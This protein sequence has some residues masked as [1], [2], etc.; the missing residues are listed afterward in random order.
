ME[1]YHLRSLCLSDCPT[2]YIY[3]SIH[4]SIH[5][6]VHPSICPSFRQSTSFDI[7]CSFWSM[8]GTMFSFAC[9]FLQSSSFR[10]HHLWQPSDLDLYIVTPEGLLGTW[11]FTSTSCFVSCNVEKVQSFPRKKKSIHT[12]LIHFKGDFVWQ[13]FRE[14]SLKVSWSVFVYLWT[15]YS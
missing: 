15:V 10:W 2:L 7:G 1:W 6:P 9:N 13:W 8:Q 11:R 3:P 12:L 5:S 4:Q 14:T